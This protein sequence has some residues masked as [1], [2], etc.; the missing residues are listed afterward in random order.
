MTPPTIVIGCLNRSLLTVERAACMPRVS[1]VM[2][3]MRKPA[4]VLLKK[5]IE[6]RAILLKSSV[7]MS[8]TTLL[9]THCM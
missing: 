6:C 9:L 3:E 2:R 5:S 7:R 8:V 1:F 4:G